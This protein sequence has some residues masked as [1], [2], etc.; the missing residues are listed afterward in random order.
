[1]SR[2]KSNNL[3]EEIRQFRK[4]KIFLGMGLIAIG[5][6][7]FI[8]PVIPGMVVLGL[9]V[10]LLFPRKVDQWLDKIRSFF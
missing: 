10:W 3:I 4:N 1:M 8:L 2:R 7:G 5:L 6:L 9:G